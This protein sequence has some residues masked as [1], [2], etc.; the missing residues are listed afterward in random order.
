MLGNR[1]LEMLVDR[2]DD[3]GLSE[4]QIALYVDGWVIATVRYICWLAQEGF[5]AAETV[6]IV[7]SAVDEADFDLAK[8]PVVPPS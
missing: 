4:Q 2:L 3:E 6:K 1:W 5:S 8:M 7:N